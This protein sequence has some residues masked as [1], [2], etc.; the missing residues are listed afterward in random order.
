VLRAYADPADAR[1]RRL[2]DALPERLA[3]IEACGLPATLVHGDLHSG[4][5]IGTPDGGRVILDWGDCVVG[6]PT[7]D[8]LRLTDSLPAQEAATVQA[9]WAQWWLE[10]VPGCDPLT[11]LALM[12]PVCELYYAAVYADFLA[13]IEPSEHPYHASDVPDCLA[14]AA[15]LSE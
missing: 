1:L 6:N 14:R 5:V 15:V 10:A 7:I 8:I 9:A 12:R 13:G 3:R 11:A 2:V 4:N